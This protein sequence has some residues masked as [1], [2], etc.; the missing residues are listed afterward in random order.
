MSTIQKITIQP[1]QPLI[2][3]GD[4]TI[5]LLGS[6]VILTDAE[7]SLLYFI[8]QRSPRHT[9]SNDIHSISISPA[10]LPVII[11][12]VNKKAAIISGR[13]LII[14]Q[15]GLGYRLNPYI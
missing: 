12:S 4:N 8:A 7:Y 15:R 1:I 9:T 3:K 11:S 6:S 14:S 5:V 2:F 13:R 10:S